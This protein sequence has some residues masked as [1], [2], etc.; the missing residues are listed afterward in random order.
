[1]LA[2]RRIAPDKPDFRELIHYTRYPRARQYA[3]A[4]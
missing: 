1:M 4:L 2:T 3:P